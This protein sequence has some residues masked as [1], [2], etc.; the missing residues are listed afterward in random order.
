MKV[1]LLTTSFHSLQR[2]QFQRCS[3]DT[4]KQAARMLG[5]MEAL[6]LGYTFANSWYE[7]VFYYLVVKYYLNANVDLLPENFF[8]KAL[9]RFLLFEG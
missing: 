8:D 1:T 9:T 5:S 3:R 2:E 4:P 6:V 7:M